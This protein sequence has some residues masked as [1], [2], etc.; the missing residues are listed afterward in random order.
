MQV[1]RKINTIVNT[2]LIS[3]SKS[4]SRIG[5]SHILE[6]GTNR[7]KENKTEKKKEKCHTIIVTDL[8]KVV[9]NKLANN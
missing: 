1:F 9:M 4:M 2:Y 5:F 7:I 3:L 6:N 8:I